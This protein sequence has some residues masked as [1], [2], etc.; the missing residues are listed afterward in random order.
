M[1]GEVSSGSIEGPSL[2]EAVPVTVVMAVVVGSIPDEC[3]HDVSVRGRIKRRRPDRATC[4][5]VNETDR[6]GKQATG[7]TMGNPANL[8]VIYKIYIL[9]TCP[10]SG[11]NALYIAAKL[12]IR[13]FLEK[14]LPFQRCF[15]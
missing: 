1:D 10:V 9:T 4:Q 7:F 3:M 8:E 13:A 11:K 12:P 6:R 2:L 14:K 5:I 15:P